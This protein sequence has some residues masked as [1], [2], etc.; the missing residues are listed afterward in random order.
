MIRR[1]DITAGLRKLKCRT[2]IFVGDNSPFHLEALHMIAKLDRRY[3]A[4]V[5]V[6]NKSIWRYFAKIKRKIAF[7]NDICNLE[8]IAKIK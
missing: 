8:D 5:E 4:L 7:M 6:R 2:L 1:P 3:S